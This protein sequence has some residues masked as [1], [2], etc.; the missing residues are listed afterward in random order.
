MLETFSST[1]NSIQIGFVSATVIFL[2]LE[3]GLPLPVLETG[4]RRVHH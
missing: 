4:E 2:G 1:I 3:L